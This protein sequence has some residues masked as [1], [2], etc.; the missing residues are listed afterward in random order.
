[1][2]GVFSATLKCSCHARI[3]SLPRNGTRVGLTAAVEEVTDDPSKLACSLF[4][5]GG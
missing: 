4:K 2:P 1:M 3:L 5:D